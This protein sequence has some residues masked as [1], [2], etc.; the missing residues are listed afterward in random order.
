[1]T[2]CTA[3][4]ANIISALLRSEATAPAI[5]HKLT[6]L[7]AAGPLVISPVVYA[8][9]LASPNVTPEYL[10]RF[11]TATHITVLAPPEISVW[12][13]AGLAFGAYARRRK[14][15]GASSPRRILSDFLIGAQAAQRSDQLFTLDQQH[16]RLGFPEVVLVDLN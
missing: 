7:A 1:M 12:E 15:S 13:A 14:Q 9:L 3:L 4:D 10:K 6:E 5:A 2:L 8:E 11:L 16:Y